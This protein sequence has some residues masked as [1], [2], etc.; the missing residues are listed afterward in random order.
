[1]TWQ[2]PPE[3]VNHSLG[4]NAVNIVSLVTNESTFGPWLKSLLYCFFFD[5]TDVHN[6]M[7]MLQGT[8]TYVWCPR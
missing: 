3:H 5:L 1:M 6:S 2:K 4:H 8:P 7:Q